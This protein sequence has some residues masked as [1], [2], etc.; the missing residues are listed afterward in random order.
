MTLGVFAVTQ[1]GQKSGPPPTMFLQLAINKQ[2]IV[3]GTFENTSTEKSQTIEGMV[4]KKSQRTAW[5]VTGKKWP[6]METGISNLTKD[7]APALIHFENGQTQQWLLV[8]LEEPKEGE[9]APK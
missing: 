4:D 9:T 1:D 8:R 6:I 3:A 5:S 2:G 7:S